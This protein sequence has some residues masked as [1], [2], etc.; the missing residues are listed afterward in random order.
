ME[1]QVQ[2]HHIYQ[3]IHSHYRV[4]M[5]FYIYTKDNEWKIAAAC[6]QDRDDLE[7]HIIEAETLQEAIEKFEKGRRKT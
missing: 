1:K 6:K 5:K 2:P 4:I 7:E 3:I